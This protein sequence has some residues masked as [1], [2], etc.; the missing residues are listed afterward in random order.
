M[1]DVVDA[2]K[3]QDSVNYFS[4]YQ[5]NEIS[6]EIFFYIRQ[7]STDLPATEVTLDKALKTQLSLLVGSCKS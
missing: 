7:F 2:S 4:V 6:K 1:N 5:H 3:L